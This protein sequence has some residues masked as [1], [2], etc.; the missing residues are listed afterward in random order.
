[1]A[2]RNKYATYFKAGYQQTAIS[3][4][5]IKKHGFAGHIADKLKAES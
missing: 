4:K 5:S 1:M 2:H 3:Q